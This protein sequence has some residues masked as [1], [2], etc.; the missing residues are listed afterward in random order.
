MSNLKIFHSAIERELDKVGI[1]SKFTIT[2]EATVKLCQIS[3]VVS[4]FRMEDPYK[5]ESQYTNGLGFLIDNLPK[6]IKGC[7]LRIYYDSSITKKDDKWVP[8]LDKAKSAPFVQ[9]IH[10]DFPQFKKSHDSFYHEGVFGTII[11]FFPIFNFSNIA[12]IVSVVDVDFLDVDE[13]VEVGGVITN[14]VKHMKATKTAFLFNTYSIMSYIRKPRLL[15]NDMIKKYDFT[16][17]MIVQPT[18]CAKKIDASIM[19]DFMICM[20]KRC[21]LYEDWLTGIIDGLNCEKVSVS[22]KKN[23]QQCI[24]LK[25]IKKHKSTVFAFGVDEL[26][27]NSTILEEFLK[28]KKPFLLFYQMPNFTHYH[29]NLYKRFQNR[30]ID[31]KFMC[32]MYQAILGKEIKSAADVHK[33]F[34]EVD[35]TIYINEGRGGISIQTDDAKKIY[36]LIYKFLK[37]RVNALLAMPN[38]EIYEKMMYDHLKNTDEEDFVIG[39]RFYTI[40]YLPNNKYELVPQT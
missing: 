5:D 24:Y 12:E 10:Y 26:F 34:R 39:K 1:Q 8:I 14:A 28:N 6:Y 29:Y 2:K 22:N 19:V 32:D 18:T 37:Q 9:L 17:R 40:T 11:R 13:V 30:K 15:M 35:K 4:I 16:T 31:I 38:L 33:A 3:I 25:E 27:L 23:L 36:K 20:I 21:P 7:V